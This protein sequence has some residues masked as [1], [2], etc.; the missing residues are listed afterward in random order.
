MEPPMTIKTK[1]RSAHRDSMPRS[2]R[3][4]FC[5]EDTIDSAIK[6]MHH[7]IFVQERAKLYLFYTCYN[8]ALKVQ[9]NTNIP[10]YGISARNPFGSYHDLQKI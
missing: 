10:E 1:T 6:K 4:Y 2:H 7:A 8:S 9:S 5:D 3:L